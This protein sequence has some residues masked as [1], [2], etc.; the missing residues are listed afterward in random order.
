MRLMIRVLIADDHPLIRSGVRQAL[1]QEPDFAAP[2]EASDS[3]ELLRLI[4]AEEWDVVLLDI[5]L[6]GLSGLEV[7][8]GVRKRRPSAAVL[9]LSVHSEEHFAIRAI[10]MGA[11]GFVSKTSMA[12]ELVGAI[13]SVA[14]GKKHISPTVAEALARTVGADRDRPL[15]ETLS[16]REFAVM[17]AIAQ[18][19]TVSEIAAEAPLSVKT[20]STYR[21]RALE[22]MCMRTNAEFMLYAVRH[23]LVD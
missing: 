12:Q 7:L 9:V 17:R 2:G 1:A 3:G 18:G 11:K 13:R 23:G 8:P 5:T 10:R 19:K 4:D 16:H 20:V 21:S 6:P 14:A 15:H 22:K